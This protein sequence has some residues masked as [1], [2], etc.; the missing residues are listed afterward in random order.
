MRCP[1]T[2][3]FRNSNCRSLLVLSVACIPIW[4][5]FKYLFYDKNSFG[6]Q[7]VVPVIRQSQNLPVMNLPTISQD[8]FANYYRE[9]TYDDPTTYNGIVFESLPPLKSRSVKVYMNE[10]FTHYP[11]SKN[12]LNKTLLVIVQSHPCESAYR[13][14]WRSAMRK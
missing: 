13:D 6:P 5:I 8:E 11:E 14:N 3:F 2:K 1:K 9:Y 4:L 10:T 12:F 7:S